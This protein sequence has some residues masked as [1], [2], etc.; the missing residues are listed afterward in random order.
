M[1]LICSW[2]WQHKPCCCRGTKESLH[3]TCRLRHIIVVI[4]SAKTQVLYMV[5]L[6]CYVSGWAWEFELGHH[7]HCWCGTFNHILLQIKPATS[8]SCC[9][10]YNYMYLLWPFSIGAVIDL[11]SIQGSIL[12]DSNPA[13]DRK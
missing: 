4:P 6:K 12:A 10:L 5:W 3:A 1:F 9:I 2:P 11:D 7:S 8:R 13:V